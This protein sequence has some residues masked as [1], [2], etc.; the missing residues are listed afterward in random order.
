MALRREGFGKRPQQRPFFV[1][2]GCD[3]G[4]SV[5][6]QL[7]AVRRHDPGGGRRESHALR[8]SLIHI[9]VLS[10]NPEAGYHQLY[11]YEF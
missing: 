4:R 6:A 2:K 3:N 11:T 10:P 9:Y 7:R 8:L 1:E 5:H